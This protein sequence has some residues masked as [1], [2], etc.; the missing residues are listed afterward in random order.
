[1]PIRDAGERVA[2]SSLLT[3]TTPSVS[4]VTSMAT[5]LSP[6]LFDDAVFIDAMIKRVATLDQ[7]NIARNGRPSVSGSGRPK[8]SIMDVCGSI[9]M[10]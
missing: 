7:P 1:M 4:P 2:L 3:M 8:R 6:R 10:A 9:P 5:P